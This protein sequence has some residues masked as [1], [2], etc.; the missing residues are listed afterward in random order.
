M[1]ALFQF[2]IVLGVVAS[3]ASNLLLKDVGPN[4]WRWMLGVEAVPALAFPVAAESVPAWAIF[5]FFGTMMVFHFAWAYLFV[6][7]TKGTRLA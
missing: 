7:E 5:A 1:T 6:P 4:A 2:N 3:L